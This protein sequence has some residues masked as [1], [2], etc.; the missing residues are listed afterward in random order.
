MNTH[1][2]VF[3]P[4]GKVSQELKLVKIWK[5]L[6]K[7]EITLDA[8]IL[9]IFLKYMIFPDLLIPVEC[10]FMLVKD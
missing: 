9:Q 3:A 6:L 5:M 1:A 7:F 2:R 4:N 8:C 10:N